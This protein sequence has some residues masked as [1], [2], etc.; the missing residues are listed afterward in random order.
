MQ[1]Y[2]YSENMISEGQLGIYVILVL[3]GEFG[4]DWINLI[5]PSMWLW[6]VRN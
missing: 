4:V 6:S 5:L 2:K 1:N 3:K